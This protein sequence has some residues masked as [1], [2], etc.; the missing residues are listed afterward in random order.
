MSDRAPANFSATATREPNET[1]Q[2]LTQKLE[3]RQ[4]LDDTLDLMR[5]VLVELSHDREA[6]YTKVEAGAAASASIN[7][8]LLT[9]LELQASE[10]R[11]QHAEQ[12]GG[13]YWHLDK[14]QRFS[15]HYV[16]WREKRINA[17]IQHYG[18]EFFAGKKVLEL[19]CGYGEIGAAFAHLGAKVTCSDARPEHL[20]VVRQRHPK[21]QT[22]Q[23]DLDRGWPFKGKWDLI[24]HLGLLYHLRA[25]EPSILWACE[26]GQ[27]VVLET[28]VCDSLD[29][30]L[31]LRT[32]ESGYDQANNG[33]G[34]RP[35]TGCIETI[36]G[37]CD[38]IFD[39]LQDSSCNSGMH[40]YDWA[41][42]NTGSWRHG[43][44]RL[45]FV[46][47]NPT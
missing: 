3:E 26:A 34:C 33:R 32:Q 13:R 45:W 11:Q 44:R 2:R 22:V 43:L 29:P 16:D 21:V 40:T 18:Q 15:E 46:S 5:N 23:A 47:D 20:D 4:G 35:S 19:G 8:M 24:L 39:R 12:A 6:L 10:I 25:P 14:T 37:E 17:I 1:K 27:H 38:K 36:L 9:T 41:E 30:R 42:L 7:Q 31:I 28:E